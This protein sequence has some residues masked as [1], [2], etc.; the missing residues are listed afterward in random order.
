MSAYW[1]I[2]LDGRPDDIRKLSIELRSLRWRI[3]E[4]DN[5]CYLID[6]DL[7]PDVSPDDVNRHASDLVERLRRS[8]RLSDGRMPLIEV[9]H[10]VRV[11]NDG[12]QK[13]YIYVSDSID[14]IGRAGISA[15][16][17][18]GTS[19]QPEP[20]DI[21][22]WTILAYKHDVVD[23]VMRNIGDG[24]ASYADL[25]K[26]VERIEEDLKQQGMQITALINLNDYKALM[27]NLQNPALSG[28]RAVHAYRKKGASRYMAMPDEEVRQ[29]VDTLVRSWLEAKARQC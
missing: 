12:T 19:T 20:T 8:V 27:E 7:D 21:E 16:A 17:S 13:I 18:G 5:R 28:D 23:K 25:R 6:P 26:A 29:T 14:I 11:N 15:S 3:E 9:Q 4:K 2:G 24:N 22:I 1:A 10:P